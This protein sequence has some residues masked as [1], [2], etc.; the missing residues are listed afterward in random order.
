M[1]GALVLVGGGVAT[2]GL[3]LTRRSLE[4]TVAT[5][6][7]FF[8]G[9]WLLERRGQRNLASGA[10][11]LGLGLG[12]VISD[13]FPTYRDELIF[14]GIGGGLLL[15]QTLAP[16]SARGAAGAL[17][18]VAVSE[19]ALTWLPPRVH[20]PRVYGAF[21]D[22][23]GFGIALVAWGLMAMGTAWRGRRLH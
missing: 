7:A 20:A 23:W 19:W 8:V 11:L 10:V 22:G 15:C 21:D 3:G 16:G 9:A 14:A 5:L 17:G 12:L 13:H 2:I 18:G 6:G 1:R 4:E